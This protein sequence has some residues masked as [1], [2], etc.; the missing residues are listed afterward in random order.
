MFSSAVLTIS[1]V[2]FM[3]KGNTE[4]YRFVSGRLDGLASYGSNG[5]SGILSLDDGEYV[6]IQ[7]ASPAQNQTLG[8]MLVSLVLSEQQ[9]PYMIANKGALVSSDLPGHVFFSDTGVMAVNPS[10]RGG[11]NIGKAGE[12]TFP[13]YPNRSL[14]YNNLTS[15]LQ[16]AFTGSYPLTVIIFGI[17]NNS[18][19]NITYQTVTDDVV[20]D[21]AQG[22]NTFRVT[23]AGFPYILDLWIWNNVNNNGKILYELH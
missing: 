23:E 15:K 6:D 18:F 1:E 13:Y 22:I 8:D 5:V 10:F 14:Y 4:P 7:V 19:N 12:V 21:I 17:G 11:I 9:A 16:F 20:F 2:W 3:A